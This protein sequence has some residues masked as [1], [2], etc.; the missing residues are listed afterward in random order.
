MTK[1]LQYV[2]TYCKLW[3][4]LEVARKLEGRHVL[5]F[6][7]K[8][9]GSEYILTTVPG[10]K[11]ASFDFFKFPNMYVIVCLSII[12]SPVTHQSLCVIYMYMI[13]GTGFHIYG[14]TVI[15]G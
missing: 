9:C 5:K 10:S 6:V 3:H 15:L 1:Q 12:K 4:L 8:T 14:D 13:I 11:L 7:F 2:R